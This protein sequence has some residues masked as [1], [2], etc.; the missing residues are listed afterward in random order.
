LKFLKADGCSIPQHLVHD[1]MI[2]GHL[3]DPVRSNRLKDTAARMLGAEAKDGQSDL[4]LAYK[5]GGWDFRT[6]PVDHPAYWVYS[7]LDTVLT[8]RVVEKLWK[9]TQPYRYAYEIEMAFIHV[10]RDAEISGMN[11]DVPYV[12]RAASKYE[13]VKG[14]LEAYLFDVY[15]LVKPG[16]DAQVIALLQRLG[17]TLTHRTDR[18]NISVDNEVLMSL[19]GQFPVA[20]VIQ[21]YRRASYLLSSFFWKL[22]ELVDSS[23]AVHPSTKPVG[24]RTGR[25]SVTDPPLQTV[26]RGRVVRDAF[27]AREGHMLISA[28]YSGMELRAMAGDANEE[29]MIAAFERG[30]DVHTW[31]AAQIYSIPLEQVTRQQRDIAKNSGF[32][33]IYGAG[34]ETF[35]LTAGISMEEGAAFLDKYDELFPG[36]KI[37]QGELVH[38]VMQTRKGHEWGWAE[39][40]FGRHL[41]I[42]PGEEYKAPNYRIQG[43]CA[44]A[45]K[46]R[47]IALDAAGL[48][49]FFRLFVHDEFI[50]EV[51]TEY[52][53][54]VLARTIEIMRD[55]QTF[56]RLPL[57]AEGE[58]V[59]RWGDKY[60]K[61]KNGLLDVDHPN[62]ELEAA[63]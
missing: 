43:G 33:K 15:G 32:A 45:A 39:T 12:R 42:E 38:K 31:T 50:L 27:V 11:V 49:E 40:P 46:R 10:L 28:D 23:G 17:A 4:K 41:S 29:T 24:A 61:E 59:V 16:S 1:G 9:G 62:Y 35:S 14:R 52:V 8:S 3:C 60:S 20:G 30:D 56:P 51:P 37:W 63:V 53:D 58:T 34:V 47:A 2:M 7:A 26:P 19:K 44:E 13:E 21:E 22:Q 36:V 57:V 25:T 5:N 18:G 48:G 55:D 54:E 6:I